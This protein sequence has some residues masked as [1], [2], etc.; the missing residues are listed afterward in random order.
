MLLR[1]NTGLLQLAT[2][3]TDLDNSPK[4]RY[5]IMESYTSMVRGIGIVVMAITILPLLKVGGMQLFKMEGPDSTEKILPRT[6]EVATIIIS[7]YLIL[8][9]MCGMFYWLFGMSIFDSVAHAMT[10]IA[11][12]GFCNS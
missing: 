5:F 1:C 7:T 3:I 4:E 9:F 6:I 12:G 8:T 10:T 2:I 11:T